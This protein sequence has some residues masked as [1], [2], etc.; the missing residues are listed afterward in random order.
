MFTTEQSDVTSN[1][2]P[3]K[4]RNSARSRSQFASQVCFY[5]SLDPGHGVSGEEYALTS[6]LHI[7]AFLYGFHDFARV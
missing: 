7:S 4:L 1:V 3:S 2:V 5:P 6:F